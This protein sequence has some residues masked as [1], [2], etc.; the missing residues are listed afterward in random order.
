MSSFFGNDIHTILGKSLILPLFMVGSSI[1]YSVF[2]E[3]R[4]HKLVSK[5]FG[6]GTGTFLISM[7]TGL[8][9]KK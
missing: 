1:I 9:L 6:Y 8:A 3:D 4:D 5:A 2:K 7:A